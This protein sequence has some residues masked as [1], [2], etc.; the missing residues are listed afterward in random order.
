[1]NVAFGFEQ[2]AGVFFSPLCRDRTRRARR[3]DF[4]GLCDGD[5]D[6]ASKTTASVVAVLAAAAAALAVF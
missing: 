2:C 1:M 3:C 6:G 4:D 5:L